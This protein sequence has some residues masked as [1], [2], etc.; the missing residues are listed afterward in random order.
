[1]TKTIILT[2]GGTGGHIFPAQAV[3]QKLSEQGF[4]AI[5]F[6][7]KNYRKYH[8]ADKPYKCR[9][10]SSSQL[11]KSPLAL[12]KA[13]IKIFWGV[14]QSLFWIVKYQPKSVVAFG[15]YS[16]FPVLIAAVILRKR[17]I[18]HEQNAHLGKANLIFAKFADR[19]A[20]SY[21]QTDGIK[22]IISSPIF[23]DLAH[24]KNS[25]AVFSK[26]GLEL[27][28]TKRDCSSD[29]KNRA[30]QVH[31]KFILTGNPIRE[32]ILALSKNEYHLPDFNQKIQVI[33]NLGYDVLLASQFYNHH[34]GNAELFNILVLGG[35]G[36]AKIFSDILPK[37]LFNL[38]DE[39][40]NHL[41]IT[42]QCRLENLSV[43]FEQYKS[44]N[45]NI[46][47]SHFFENMAEEISKAH[48]VISRSGSSSLAEFACAKKPMILVPF[49]LAADNHQEKNAL[50]IEKAGGAIVI[51][52]ADFTINNVTTTLEKLIDN[53]V[54]L[55][56]MS[57]NA[58]KCA[59]LDATK[60]LIKIINNE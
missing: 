59:H 49:A 20:L 35:S 25:K 11:N 16:T 47:I 41:H 45:I 55:Q 10:I 3:A 29:S 23:V 38:R 53:P 44:F 14:L 37:A 28:E 34:N 58:F 43:T 60:N 50:A 18:L 27:S 12:F 42:Q 33:D 9:I 54:T 30:K 7:N 52:E 22:N 48:L 26:K 56:K 15:G 1:M 13:G 40:K 17:I 36:G 46:V 6:G 57:N 32:G 4:R 39:L 51:K 8:K 21:E 2:T 5:V 19:I 31:N 24:Q